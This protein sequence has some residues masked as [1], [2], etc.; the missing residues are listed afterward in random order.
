MVPGRCVWR[1]KASLL[2]I[3]RMCQWTRRASV[4]EVSWTMAD[5]KYLVSQL[6]RRFGVMPYSAGASLSRCSLQLSRLSHLVKNAAKCVFKC[7]ETSHWQKLF[8][9]LSQLWVC[10]CAFRRTSNAYGRKQEWWRN[11]E[12]CHSL[13]FPVSPVFPYASRAFF[14]VSSIVETFCRVVL[15]DSCVIVSMTFL[16]LSHLVENPL[17]LNISGLGP[18]MHESVYK[19]LQ[20][21]MADGVLRIVLAARVNKDIA[22][23]RPFLPLIALWV[24][25]SY[26]N[27]IAETY[28]SNCEIDLIL[29]CS[30]FSKDVTV[31]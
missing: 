5:A 25:F 23:M 30:I 18:P 1:I 8:L 19:S 21:P 24:V 6:E 16:L 2:F 7:V 28:Q 29:L 12:S 15:A 9:P 27:G 14:K 4:I 26:K 17:K 11:F 22:A 10:Y 13:Q 31:V 20:F 3:A